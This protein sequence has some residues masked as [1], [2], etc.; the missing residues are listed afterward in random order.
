MRISDWSSGVCSSDLAVA[1]GPARRRDDRDVGPVQ[2]RQ[3]R[4]LAGVVHPQLDHRELGVL[5]HPGQRQQIGSAS[6]RESVFQYVLISL[7][8]FTLTKT[9][10][11]NT[12]KPSCISTSFYISL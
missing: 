1:P 12:P 2:A 11:D 10:G 4:H 8:A 3:R 9:T 5:R 7:C 6:G